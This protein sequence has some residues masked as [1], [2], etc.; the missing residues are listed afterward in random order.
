[1]TS[2][3]APRE[4]P[5][6]LLPGENR[7]FLSDLIQKIFQRNKNNVVS[8]WSMFMVQQLIIYVESFP[9]VNFVG[10]FNSDNQTLRIFAQSQA[11]TIS[12]LLSQ[13]WTLEVYLNPVHFN[14]HTFVYCVGDDI[15]KRLRETGFR[16]DPTTG[17]VANHFKYDFDRI[18]AETFSK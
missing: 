2:I 13:T 7:Y 8:R 12:Q 3:T 4:K 17:T 9:G 14:E 10:F 18:I 6:E 16:H 5:F 1:M 11:T 15:T